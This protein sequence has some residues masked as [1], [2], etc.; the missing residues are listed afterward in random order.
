MALLDLL[1]FV[2]TG[3]WGSGLARPLTAAEADGNVHNLAAAIQNLIDNPVE[4]VSVTNIA[5]SGRQVTFYMSDSSTYGPFT[6]PVA[7][8]RYRGQWAALASYAVLDIVQVAGYGTYLVAV[9]HT[10]ASSFDPARTVSGDTVYVQ[11]APDANITP[12]VVTTALGALTLDASHA[13]KYIRCTNLSGIEITLDAGVFP[14]NTEIH[15][16]QVNSGPIT[17]IA[18]SDVAINVPI[19]FDAGSDSLGAVFTLKHTTDDSWDI[20]GRLA[21][22]SA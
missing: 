9:D 19:G 11:I 12:Q 13:G 1:K 7:T 2:T 18:S 14:A 21:E 22:V 3:A 4:G 15:F 10:A 5:V 17:I 20:F 16:R 8:P 6:L